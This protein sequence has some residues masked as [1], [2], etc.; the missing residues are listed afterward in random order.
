[1][2][3]TNH[4]LAPAPSTNPSPR[5]AITADQQALVDALRAALVADEAAAP[6]PAPPGPGDRFYAAGAMD[7]VELACFLAQ[8]DWK[9]A[10]AAAQVR[11]AK[12]WRNELG[13]LSIADVAPFLR[14]PAPG[15]AHPDGCVVLLEDG[16]GGVAR[17][18]RGRPILLSLG[19][20]HGSAAEMQKQM[21]YALERA[22]LHRL[23]GHARGECCTVIEIRP[24]EPGAPVTFRFPDK[25]VRTL[26]DL[27]ARQYP[28]ALASTTHFCGLPRA[29][30]WAFRLCKPFMARE[31]YENMKL[32][33]DFGHL[34]KGKER[35]IGA[36]SDALER[37]GGALAFDLDAYVAWRA[38]DEGVAATLAAAGEGRAF[39]AAAAAVADEAAMNAMG[40]SGHVTAPAL[41]ADAEA[42]RTHGV[43]R[44]RGSGRGLFA[45]TR[46][47]AKLAV[48]TRGGALV[49]F[50]STDEAD[51]RNGAARV[52]PLA[53]ARVERRGADASASPGFFGGGS[54]AAAAAPPAGAGWFAV[55]T[56][57]REYLFAADAE[58]DA[59]RWVA[60]INA[61]IDERKEEIKTGKPRAELAQAT[62]V[63]G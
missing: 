48:L 17:D 4:A 62:K 21:V 12:A 13:E 20:T 31:A 49:Y 7:D 28:G 24:R 51:E 18:A 8:R 3:V 25:D 39:D 32:R 38:A 50:D 58:A 36:E 29:V 55:V 53:A 46:W 1:M 22:S 23:P 26:F 16:R 44:K 56:G 33:P 41:L 47:K 57:E 59:E 43:L 35:A 40:A 14:A 61:E 42:V 19:M 52:I 5:A 37:W 9:P 45:T 27:Q 2:A 10:D 30:T 60:E 63:L 6:P 11:A 54:A 34:L 15:R